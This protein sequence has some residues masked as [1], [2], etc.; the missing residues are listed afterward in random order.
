MFGR[1]GTPAQ[2]LERLREDRS[3]LDSVLEEARALQRRVGPQD[4]ARI[5]DYLDDVR[6]IERR[7]QR[8]EAL[9]ATRV[10]ALDAP[11]GVPESF[12]EH[13]ALMFDLRVAYQADIPRCS[14]S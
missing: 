7:I 10:T 9:N 8:T 14:R 1:A 3:I 11:L 2:R 6:E 12:E 4:R 5:S 13:A